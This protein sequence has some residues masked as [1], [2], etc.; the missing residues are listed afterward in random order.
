[1]QKGQHK[2]VGGSRRLFAA[3]LA[4]TVVVQLFNRLP[5]MS[6]I[7]L[8]G[9]R[10]NTRS[11]V[12]FHIKKQLARAGLVD[13]NCRESLEACGIYASAIDLS[14]P[15]CTSSARYWYNLRVVLV[16]SDRCRM[17]PDEAYEIRRVSPAV[18]RKKDY[19]IRSLS[20]MPDHIHIALRANPE[21]SPEEAALAFQ[22]NIAGKLVQIQ[23]WEWN[24]YVGTFGEY[25]MHAVHRQQT[26]HCSGGANPAAAGTASPTHRATV[27][28]PG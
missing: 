5:W 8:C 24:Y 7:S 22:N 14:E 2:A 9:A 16:A 10:S 13:P 4:M 3:R 15:T 12:E 25:A 21:Q 26:D 18:A 17:G 28:A 20:V 19:L 27:P 23:F 6:P 1:M 11:D